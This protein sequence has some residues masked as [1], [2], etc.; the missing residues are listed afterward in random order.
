MS[1]DQIDHRNDLFVNGFGLIM[2]I[3][4]TKYVWWL[5]PFGGLSIG[6]LILFSWVSTAFDHVWLLVGRSAPREFLNK[7]IYMA[8]VHDDRIRKVDTVS[9][10]TYSDP[11]P[12][13]Y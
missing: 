7:C 8:V 5:D 12:K 3:L 6:C 9:S 13:G 11:V 4:G 1:C 2:S 10:G